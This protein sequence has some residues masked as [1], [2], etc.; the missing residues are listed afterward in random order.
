MI[1][2]LEE[3]KRIVLDYFNPDEMME[4]VG[5][6]WVIVDA[7]TVQTSWGWMF[8]VDSRV[9]QETGNPSHCVTGG[10]PVV[11]EKSDGSLHFLGPGGSRR[12]AL[13]EYEAQ[14]QPTLWRKFVFY[15][16]AVVEIVETVVRRD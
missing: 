4:A 5:D 6:E 15:C 12:V 9:Y 1:E 7:D 16:Y 8:H 14:R 10:G 11:L 13:K 3:A 2:T